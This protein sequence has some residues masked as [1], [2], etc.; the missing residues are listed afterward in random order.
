MARA[1]SADVAAKALANNSLRDVLAAI[2]ALACSAWRLSSSLLVLD[3]A[4]VRADDGLAS[5][6]SC[7]GFV[8][9]DIAKADAVP[10]REDTN[11]IAVQEY[12]HRAA[13]AAV[14]EAAYL[15][16]ISA[17][18]CVV[19]LLKISNDRLTYV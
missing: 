2:M 17:H 19:A 9:P 12:A 3:A 15:V 4:A 1:D 14:A 13:A 5:S 10:T 11:T 16:I 7:A 8:V 6:T 18:V